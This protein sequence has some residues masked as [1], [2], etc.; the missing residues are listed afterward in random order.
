MSFLHLV[1]D[2]WIAFSYLFFCDCSWLN[3]MLLDDVFVKC[4]IESLMK[5]TKNRW[6]T[7]LVSSQPNMKLSWDSCNIPFFIKLSLLEILF[8]ISLHTKTI[9]FN[10]MGP[11]QATSNFL[12]SS[13]T[14]LSI[15]TKQA[16]LIEIYSST[17]SIYLHH[18][19]V[20][21]LLGFSFWAPLPTWILWD[22]LNSL[23]R[24]KFNFHSSFLS[25][26][27]WQ[28]G[29]WKNWWRVKIFSYLRACLVVRSGELILVKRNSDSKC[30]VFWYVHVKVS[31][32][33]DLCV[34]IIFVTKIYK[35]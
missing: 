26:N 28:R 19:L 17:T 5:N 12:Y 10:E 4:S 29:V 31:W 2:F 33:I 13:I 32:T 3:V 18:F 25:D 24:L 30:F 21:L 23:L 16:S 15:N 9:I 6:E 22:L 1:L 14:D 20:Y 27:D 34:K 35:S 8:W 11:V 7:F